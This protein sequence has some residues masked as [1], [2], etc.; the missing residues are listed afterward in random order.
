MNPWEPGAFIEIDAESVSKAIMKCR[1]EI[2][3]LNHE[4]AILRAAIKTNADEAEKLMAGWNA[5]CAFIDAHVCDPDI[6]S[7]MV[8]T[9]AEF[10]RYRAAITNLTNTTNER[11]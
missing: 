10:I 2:E 6:S 4:C 7:K 8:E 11:K 9:Y 5:A 3:R 1:K